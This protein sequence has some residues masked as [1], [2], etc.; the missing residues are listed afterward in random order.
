M[1]G[2]SIMVCHLCVGIEKKVG[3]AKWSI[4]E[5]DSRLWEVSGW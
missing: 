5:D 2:V 4:D 3:H 1:S